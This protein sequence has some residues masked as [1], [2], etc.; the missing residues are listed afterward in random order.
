VV[1]HLP[2]SYDTIG[3]FFQLPTNVYVPRKANKKKK[4]NDL[5]KVSITPK[6]P[7]K[8]EKKNLKIK[9]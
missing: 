7:Y 3:V 1:S 9:C 4:K 6:Y 5:K 8:F 2:L